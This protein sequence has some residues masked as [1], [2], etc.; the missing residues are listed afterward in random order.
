MDTSTTK[1]TTD[2]INDNNT[3]V[4]NEEEIHQVE[5]DLAQTSISEL[6]A[7]DPSLLGGEDV[8]ELLQR[9]SSADSM[10]QGMES[11]IDSVLQ[12]L[13]E[14][15]AL[16]GAKETD[17]AGPTSGASAPDATKTSSDA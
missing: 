12:N 16:L 14:L 1:S 7:E 2:S 11:K 9:L 6:L 4:A 10:A 3:I 17:D 13:D 15:L 5:F 8:A